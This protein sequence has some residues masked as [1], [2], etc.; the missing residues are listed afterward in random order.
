MNIDTIDLISDERGSLITIEQ[1]NNIPFDLKRFFCIFDNSKN[2][3]RGANA[4]FETVQYLFALRGSCEIILDNGR[5]QVRSFTLD[6]PTKGLLQDKLIWGCM[7]NFSKDCV[8]AVLASTYY[9]TQDYI[10]SYDQFLD[11]VSNQ[12][13]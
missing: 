2:L 4:H 9:D 7:K 1:F 8:L 5:G 3:D 12:S 6:C 10:H 11:I 13:V